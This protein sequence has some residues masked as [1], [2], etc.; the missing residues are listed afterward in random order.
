M[1]A[2]V[3]VRSNRRSRVQP[4][5]KLPNHLFGL[6][7]VDDG[8]VRITTRATDTIDQN[9]SVFVTIATVFAISISYEAIA[10][11]CA[12]FLYI[13][14]VLPIA[15]SLR[16]YGRGWTRMGPWH[17]GRWY[18]PLAFLCVLGCGLLIVVGVQPPNDM[19]Y[20]ISASDA[21]PTRT[22]AHLSAARPGGR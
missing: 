15:L 11:I 3:L 18:R 1:G 17:L 5:K 8:M 19:A 4:A 7:V 14:Y 16:V 22:G 20:L 2:D 9:D 21:Y 6:L 13:A 12:I 10:A